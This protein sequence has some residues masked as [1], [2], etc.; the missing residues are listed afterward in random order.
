MLKMVAVSKP[1]IS[2]CT[3]A[4]GCRYDADGW[5]CLAY[6]GRMDDGF[7][8]QLELRNCPCKSTLAIPVSR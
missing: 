6:V 5:K 8:G 1:F 7:G 3:C 2:V 4:C